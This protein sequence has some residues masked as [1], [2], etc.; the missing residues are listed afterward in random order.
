[1]NFW[2]WIILFVVLMTVYKMFIEPPR[3]SK[4]TPLQKAYSFG[5]IDTNPA[6]RVSAYFDRCSPENFIDCQ[7][8]QEDHGYPLP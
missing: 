4:Y 8:P 1:M 3:R 2:N 6:R 5:F 7:R